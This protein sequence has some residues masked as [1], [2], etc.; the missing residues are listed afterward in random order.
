[1]SLSTYIYTFVITAA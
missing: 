1:M